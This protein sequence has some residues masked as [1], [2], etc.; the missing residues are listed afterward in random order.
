MFAFLPYVSTQRAAAPAK[1]FDFTRPNAEQHLKLIENFWFFTSDA[2]V[3]PYPRVL[4]HRAGRRAPGEDERE[5]GRHLHQAVG[6]S[7][8][9]E[10]PSRA[11]ERGRLSRRARELCGRLP[12]GVGRRIT[13]SSAAPTR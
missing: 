9:P 3:L 10:V 4:V 6:A 12:A 8:V 1:R 5:L 2:S 7:A 13:T 11:H